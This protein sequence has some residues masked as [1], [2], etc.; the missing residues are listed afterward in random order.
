MMNRTRVATWTSA[1]LV[2]AALPAFSQPNSEA[3]LYSSAKAKWEL[4]IRPEVRAE[5][6]PRWAALNEKLALL[7][8]AKAGLPANDPRIAALEALTA[9]D[10]KARMQGSGTLRGNHGN[11]PGTNGA[12]IGANNFLK[13]DALISEWAR[14]G[15]E[16]TV[17]R[18]MELNKVLGTGLQHNG[19]PP[20]TIRRVTGENITAGGVYHYVPGTHV[21]EAMTDFANW[22]ET[23]KSAGMAPAELAGKA[24]MRLCSIHPFWD[25]NGRTTRMLMDWV[26]RSNGFPPVVLQDVLVAVF[27][28]RDIQNVPAEKAVNEV[29]KGLEKALK[30]RL[31][32]VNPNSGFAT[33]RRR[34]GPVESNRFPAGEVE[35]LFAKIREASKA[36]AEAL[37]RSAAPLSSLE[38]QIVSTNDVLAKIE[39]RRIQLSVGLLNEIHHRTAGLPNAK[40]ARAR[41]LGL[42][43]GHEVSHALGV[44]AERIADATSLRILE[45]AGLAPNPAELKLALDVFQRP[46]GA[47]HLDRFLGRL[48]DLYRYGT[49]RGRLANLERAARGE[50][51]RLAQ[52]RRGDGTLDW[53]RV[54]KAGLFREGGALGH[55]TL[56]LF[57][58]ELAVVA[59]SGDRLRIEE[60]FDGLMTT[61]FFQHYGLFALGARGGELLYA[62]YLERHV[63]GGFVNSVLKNQVV[64]AAGLALP[65][66]ASGHFSGK[67]FAISLGSLGLSSAAVKAGVNSLKWV[68]DLRKP[69]NAGR[70]AALGRRSQLLAKASKLGAWVYTAGE[71]AVVLYVADEI[72]EAYYTWE[73]RRAAKGELGREVQGLLAVANDPSKGLPELRAALAKEEG[74]WGSYRNYLYGP[75]HEAEALFTQRLQR[76]AVKAKQIADQRS[77]LIDQLPKRR[78]ISERATERYGSPEAY[79]EALIQPKREALSRD[80]RLA[81]QVYE[82]E[83]IEAL[84]EIYGERL[85]SRELLADVDALDWNLRG[86][87]EGAAGDPFAKR[88]DTFASWGRK[89][90]RDSFQNAVEDVSDNRLQAY[91]DQ[92]DL[93][94]AIARGLRRSGEHA[95]AELFEDAHDRALELQRADEALILGPAIPATR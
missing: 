15:A 56:A 91:Q 28:A 23:S 88:N 64:L 66:I 90:A 65:Q 87:A 34:A 61:D 1:L 79:A 95:R 8:E 81:L 37:G 92:A 6:E 54:G 53:K 16:M 84:Q 9:S 58:K 55:F 36:R 29:T 7:K 69:A 43:L 52:Y 73:S 19:R 3:E 11:V 18:L 67:T 2:A 22:Y 30:A 5:L 26:L 20:G 62:R 45:R 42:I 12:S 40:E 17:E 70:L 47:T 48:R 63:R 77:G 59:H 33:R 31:E 10:Q 83:R 85:R 86:G 75:L 25:G 35:A 27:G 24:Y 72:S 94:A 38:L 32:I 93:Y 4:E 78:G 82:R 44:K 51:D 39:G 49:P 74:A 50:V 46:T 60:F 89:R 80:A 71:L 41:I 13:A 76:L 14:T 21:S 57:L 68:Y